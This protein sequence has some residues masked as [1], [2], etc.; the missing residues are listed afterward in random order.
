MTPYPLGCN[1]SRR[2]HVRFVSTVT[3]TVFQFGG[4]LPQG[5]DDLL[6]DH[7]RADILGTDL[8]DAGLVA[9]SRGEDRTEMRS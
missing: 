4:H 6:A 7:V 2:K 1:G 3:V 9:V 8:H 5:D